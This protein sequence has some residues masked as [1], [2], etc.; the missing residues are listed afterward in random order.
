[1]CPLALSVVKLVLS[2][3]LNVETD[4]GCLKLGLVASSAKGGKQNRL[5]VE[6]EGLIE[7]RQV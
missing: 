1:M 4:L 5:R 6:Q 3:V 2:S 7:P